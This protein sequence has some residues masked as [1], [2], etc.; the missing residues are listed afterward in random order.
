MDVDMKL[1]CRFAKVSLVVGGRY[2]V[3][4]TVEVDGWRRE[5]RWWGYQIRPQRMKSPSGPAVGLNRRW[6]WL[7]AA[8][9][10]SIA[11]QTVSRWQ[12]SRNDEKTS[13]Q[14]RVIM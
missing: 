5:G 13:Q 9:L 11:Q 8:C 10:L 6:I 7:S 4:F 2:G 1:V 3:G 12:V 14:L